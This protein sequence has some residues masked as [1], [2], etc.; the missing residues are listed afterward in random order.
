MS[1]QT[2]KPENPHAFP[3]KE[4][5]S[6]GGDRWD[7]EHT[8]GMTLRDWF[9]GQVLAGMYSNRAY[10]DVTL[11]ATADAAYHMADAM[12]CARAKDRSYE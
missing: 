8:P 5:V 10:D 11:P 9:A 7:W 6:Y 3:C 2:T 1:E 12:L 4:R